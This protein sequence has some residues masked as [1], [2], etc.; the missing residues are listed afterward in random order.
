MYSVWIDWQPKKNLYKADVIHRKTA[1]WLHSENIR[2]NS[3]FC[4]SLGSNFT[5]KMSSKKEKYFYLKKVGPAE[6]VRE[7]LCW[8]VRQLFPIGYSWYCRSHDTLD[9]K[10]LNPIHNYYKRKIFSDCHKLP[11]TICS[12]KMR[13]I[14]PDKSVS[15]SRGKAGHTETV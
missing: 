15:S 5:K 9:P 6:K 12:V 10:T 4:P 11:E 8:A 14:R 3:W 13:A 2:G 1:A 7:P